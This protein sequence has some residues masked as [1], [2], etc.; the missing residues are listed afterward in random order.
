MELPFRDLAALALRC[1]AQTEGNTVPI[2]G[3]DRR[4]TIF[5][6]P[7]LGAAD[8]ADPIFDSFRSPD[9][10]GE[11]YMPPR[12]WMPGAGTVQ[13][14]AFPYTEAVRRSNGRPGETA[15][16]VEWTLG[17]YEGEIFLLSFA[18]ALQKELESLGFACLRPP[19]DPRFGLKPRLL[20]GNGPADFRMESRW[21]ERHAAFACGLGTFGLSRGLITEKGMAVRFVSLI[22]DAVTEPTPRTYTAYDEWC[23]RCGACGRRCPAEAISLEYGKNNIRCKQWVDRTRE[24]YAP[25]YGCGKCQLAV[26]C[27]SRRPKKA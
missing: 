21:S 12:A 23:I 22:T 18:G 9:V 5:G 25:R 3:E 20:E 2:P 7:I 14:F 17:R 4:L 24:L 11:N 10:I 16:S 27:E 15:T 26:P 19:G 6:E 13:S 8:A 1:A